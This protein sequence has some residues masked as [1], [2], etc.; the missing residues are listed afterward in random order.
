MK[1][2]TWARRF[3]KNLIFRRP[4]ASFWIV[5][6]LPTIL[7]ELGTSLQ[8]NTFLAR[9]ALFRYSGIQCWR[10]KPESQRWQ[11][12]CGTISSFGMARE[13]AGLFAGPVGDPF[14]AAWAG[15]GGHVWCGEGFRIGTT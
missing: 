3:G 2:N 8:A 5:S 6:G 9:K 7:P 4:R 15:I 12:R 1:C 11:V 10:P 13:N 14:A